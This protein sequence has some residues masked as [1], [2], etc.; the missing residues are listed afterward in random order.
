MTVKEGEQSKSLPV[1]GEVMHALVE[2]GF[3][4]KDCLVSVGGG[5]VGDLGGFAASTYMRGIDFYNIPTTVLSQVD[6]SIGGKTAINYDGIKNMVGTFYQPKCVL[7]D[8]DTLRTLPRRQVANGLAEALKMAMTSSASL[9]R[10]FEEDDPF[11]QLD[12]ILPEAIG[13][14]ADVVMQD[15]KEANLRKILNF[16]H[17]IGHAIET[18][19]LPGECYH[20]ECVAL[21]MVAVTSGQVRERLLAVLKK[22]EI[23][24]RID[25]STEAVMQALLHDKKKGGESITAVLVDEIGSCRLEEVPPSFFEERLHSILRA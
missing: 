5:V 13:I 1:Y 21:G 2:H 19:K 22:L 15:E 12:R 11:M 6:S 16:G 7:V 20:G 14:K 24:T 3:T 4:R 18:T 9:F 8:P 17:T 10:I 23:P 25:F